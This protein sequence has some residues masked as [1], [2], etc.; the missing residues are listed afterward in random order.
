M[1]AEGTTSCRALLGSG[2]M[3]LLV[4]GLLL[5]EPARLPSASLGTRGGGRPAATAGLGPEAPGAALVLAAASPGKPPER[6]PRGVLGCVL[7]LALACPDEDRR[8]FVCCDVL[9]LVWLVSTPAIRSSRP[10]LQGTRVSERLTFIMTLPHS[11]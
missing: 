1:P 5:P 4:V 3:P 2:G 10:Y 9:L 6:E 7:P 8:L 11:E